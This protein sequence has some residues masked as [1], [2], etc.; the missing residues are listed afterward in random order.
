MPPDEPLVWSNVQLGFL[1]RLYV[2]DTAPNFDF[3]NF[4]G[5]RVR[6]EDY[7]GKLVLAHFW[8]TWCGPCRYATPAVKAIDERFGRDPRFVSI[9]IAEDETLPPAQRYVNAEK[10]GGVQAWSGPASNSAIVK[11]YGAATI[12][13]MILIDR[14]GKVLLA[15][16]DSSDL[17]SAVEN[18]LAL[19]K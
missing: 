19:H 15:T 14:D 8:A 1:T 7:R 2:G 6:L 9:H 10:L 18:A 12:P 11:A 13:T 4:D 5:S 3:Q 17:M 16:H